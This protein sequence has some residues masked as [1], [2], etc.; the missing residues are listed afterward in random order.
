[1]N[2][3]L[4]SGKIILLFGHMLLLSEYEILYWSLRKSLPS[5]PQPRYQVQ[6][7]AAAAAVGEP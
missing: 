2:P 6:D 5:R 4:R 3:E 7:L 1:M